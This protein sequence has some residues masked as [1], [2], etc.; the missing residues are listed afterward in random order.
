MQFPQTKLLDKGVVKAIFLVCLADGIVGLSYGSLATADGFPL[1]VPLALSTLVLAG[2]SEF[3]FIGVVAGGGSP[4]TAAAAGLLVNARHLPFGIAV[5]DL[6]GRG[7]AG[8]LGCHI[9]ND[10]SVVFGISQPKLAQRRSAFWLCGI[11][12]GLIWPISVMTGA[13]IGQF[14]PDTSVIGLDAVFPAIL[15]A[16]IFPALRQRRTRVP[17]VL[18]AALSLLA[19]PLV[20]AGMPVLFSL[21]GLLAWRSRK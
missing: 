10:E 2:A 6:V 15:I 7:P 14:I 3:L 18:G 21:L 12:I 1:W 17:A 16:L 20:P 11:G 13:A 5:K 9:M 4:F 8:W 19:T